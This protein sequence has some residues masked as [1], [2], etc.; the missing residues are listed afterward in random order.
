[1]TLDAAGARIETLARRS[2]N[3][4]THIEIATICWQSAIPGKSTT[5][6]L[7]TATLQSMGS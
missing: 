4:W 1:M 7:R 3:R 2:R 5:N 6:P